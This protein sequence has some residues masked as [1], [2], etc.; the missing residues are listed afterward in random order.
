MVT[1]YFCAF[2]SAIFIIVYAVI[3]K[4]PIGFF[5]KL[6]Q[7]ILLPLGNNEAIFLLICHSR[8]SI[9]VYIIIFLKGFLMLGNDTTNMYC[10]HFGYP[11]EERSNGMSPKVPGGVRTSN[12]FSSF[13]IND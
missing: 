6:F 1:K 12:V 7:Y 13:Y 4:T 5:L 9:I 8:L 3:S 11:V 10:G 2:M